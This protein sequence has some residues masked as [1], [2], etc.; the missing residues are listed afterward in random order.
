MARAAPFALGAVTGLLAGRR[1]G[2]GL[3]TERLRQAFGVTCLIVAMLVA[4]RILGWP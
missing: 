4:S 1:L 3:P 2:R